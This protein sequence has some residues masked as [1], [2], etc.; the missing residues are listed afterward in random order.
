M[1]NLHYATVTTER[2]SIVVSTWT[3]A[4]GS[5]WVKMT[6][7]G[8]TL[9]MRPIELAP[10]T[11]LPAWDWLDCC[12]MPGPLH[13]D[14][15]QHRAVDRLDPDDDRLRIRDAWQDLELE[16]I[17]AAGPRIGYIGWKG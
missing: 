12:D 3:E 8:R 14:D 10:G 4:D 5:T 16:G 7:D 2:H 6:V 1:A 11:D 15:C 17:D 9:T 13:A